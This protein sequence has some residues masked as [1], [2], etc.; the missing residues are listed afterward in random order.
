M[1]QTFGAGLRFGDIGDVGP[2][3]HELRRDGA[4]YEFLVGMQDLPVAFVLIGELFTRQYGPHFFGGEVF[5]LFEQ[6][7]GDVGPAVFETIERVLLGVLDHLLAR[8]CKDLGGGWQG[9]RQKA[10]GKSQK[11][12]RLQFITSAGYLSVS[13]ATPGSSIPARNSSEAPPPVEI[14][15][16][17][18]ETPADL[19]AFSESPPPTTDTAPDCATALAIATVPLSNGGFSNTPIGPFQIIVFA[20]AIAFENSSI[21][22]GPISTPILPSGTVSPTSLGAPSF[23]SET[24]T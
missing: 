7:V 11:F 18:S 23:N 4:A 1:T 15:E 13:A 5:A 8:E 6:S 3:R 20:P 24:T 9:K 2:V 21:V 22:L 17:L 16:I 10:K 14:C 12:H 19:T